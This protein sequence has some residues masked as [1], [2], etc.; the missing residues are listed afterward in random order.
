MKETI[1]S[2][3]PRTAGPFENDEIEFGAKGIRSQWDCRK[4]IRSGDRRRSVFADF[5]YG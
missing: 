4:Q 5:P 2:V 3:H 1:E